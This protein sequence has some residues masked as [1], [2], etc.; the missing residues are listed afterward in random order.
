VNVDD[1]PFP[2]LVELVPYLQA[3]KERDPM[4]RAVIR[5]DAELPAIEIQKIMAV[6][7]DSGVPD[8]SFAAFK[9]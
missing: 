2:N 1:R 6:I 9:R 4:L 8:I 5:G 3:K 7:G